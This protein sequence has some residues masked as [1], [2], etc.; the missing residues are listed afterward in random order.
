MGV[1]NGVIKAGSYKND[2]YDSYKLY[3][4]NSC[5]EYIVLDTNKGI[6]VVNDKTSSKTQELYHE[7]QSKIQK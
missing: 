3:S 6:V 1:G 2:L 5:K 7:I 4:Y